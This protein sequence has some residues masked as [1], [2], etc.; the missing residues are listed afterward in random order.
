MAAPLPMASEAKTGS[1]TSVMAMALPDMGAAIVS[2]SADGTTPWLLS[3]TEVAT[4]AVCFAV[5]AVA[6]TTFSMLGFCSSLV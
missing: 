4:A 5:A 1:E 2:A 3:A 6:A